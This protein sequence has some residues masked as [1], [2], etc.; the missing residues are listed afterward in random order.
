MPPFVGMAGEAFFRHQP[1]QQAAIGPRFL[2]GKGKIV[3]GE[4]F[5]PVAA[6]PAA[7]TSSNS[8]PIHKALAILPAQS[9]IDG[10]RR[11]HAA[12]ANFRLLLGADQ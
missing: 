9:Q 5:E 3:G 12:Q 10:R 4:R 7:V 11:W 2:V 1:M 8:E 6:A